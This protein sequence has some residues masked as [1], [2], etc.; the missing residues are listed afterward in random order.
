MKN[1]SEYRVGEDV[2]VNMQIGN[3][4]EWRKGIVVDSREIHPEWG[5]KHRPYTMLIVECIRTYFNAETQEYYDKLNREG[6]VYADQVRS[7]Y[8]QPK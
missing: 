2:D 7:H 5:V 1:L 4:R 6:F 8:T 3:N